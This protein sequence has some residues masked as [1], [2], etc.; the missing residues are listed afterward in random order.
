[1]SKRELIIMVDMKIAGLILCV[2]TQ[3]VLASTTHFSIIKYDDA[4]QLLLTNLIAPIG[5]GQLYLQADGILIKLE[6]FSRVGEHQ[7]RVHLPCDEF[8]V[9]DSL[10]YR[11]DDVTLTLSLASIACPPTQRGGAPR[12]IYQNGLCV[13]DPKG[14][15]LW[16]VGMRLKELNGYTVYQN[17]YAIFLLNRESFIGEDINKMRNELMHCPSEELISSI[18]KQ[19]AASLFKEAEKHRLKIN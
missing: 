9:A 18:E 4:S 17:M 10:F 8:D 16:Q 5:E 7:L 13:I 12:I 19:H 6:R 3:S 1:M 14:S 2:L 15:T 11:I